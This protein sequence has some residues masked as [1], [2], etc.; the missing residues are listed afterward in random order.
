MEIVGEA[1]RAVGGDGDAVRA[2]DD[3]LAPRAL[4]GALAIEHDHGMRAA[5]EDPHVVLGVHGHR[6]RLHEAPPIG[7]R[8]PAHQRRVTHPWPPRPR[9][10]PPTRPYT[11]T[12]P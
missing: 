2:P 8:A 1:D 12:R 6:R 9:R 11:A 4:E 10:A 7:K 5:V 3:T